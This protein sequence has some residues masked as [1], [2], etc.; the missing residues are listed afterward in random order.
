MKKFIFMF[1]VFAFAL[2]V[3]CK[4]APPPAPPPPPPPPPPK[5][6]LVAFIQ[7]IGD[8]SEVKNLEMGKSV[9][10]ALSPE[11]ILSPPAEFAVV[12]KFKSEWN[13]DELLP[14]NKQIPLTIV[15]GELGSRFL[16]LDYNDLA[17]YQSLLARWPEVKFHV[18]DPKPAYIVKV[19]EKKYW[20]TLEGNLW[21]I[22]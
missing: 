3:G 8:L 12:E 14:V 5:T 11:K 15:W 17:S 1:V 21:K 20:V 7:D 4:K 16:V 13:L 9:Q 18:L 6:E 19:G 22:W 2:A 10:I